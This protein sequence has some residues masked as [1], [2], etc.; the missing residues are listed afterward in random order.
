[1]VAFGSGYEE[2]LRMNDANARPKMVP[3]AGTR[4]FVLVGDETAGALWS[5]VE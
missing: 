1:M 3:T 4:L 2:R 5:E